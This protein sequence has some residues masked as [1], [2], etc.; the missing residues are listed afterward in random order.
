MS[1]TALKKL[2][3]EGLMLTHYY[4]LTN[5]GYCFATPVAVMVT[6]WVGVKTVLVNDRALTR[7][8]AQMKVSPVLRNHLDLGVYTPPLPLQITDVCTWL[9]P[10]EP[11]PGI[12][13]S[14]VFVEEQAGNEEKKCW[15][16]QGQDV[17]T[18]DNPHRDPSKSLMLKWK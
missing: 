8:A 16:Q 7:K 2:G 15:G 3:Q 11:N 6:C 5:P 9:G 13:Y 12:H 1:S 18:T 17:Q 4:S 14:C 10:W